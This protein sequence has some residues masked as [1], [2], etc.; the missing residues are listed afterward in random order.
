MFASKDVFDIQPDIITSAK[1]LSSGYVPLAATIFSD[2]IW[3][4]ISAPNPDHVFALG[5][6]YSGHPVACAAALKNIEIIEREKICE[7]VRETGPYLEEKL[8]TLRDL[9]IVGDVR[10]SR[11]MMGV[12]NVKNIETKE[13]F[14]KETNIASRIAKKC[15]ESGVIVRP[16]GNFIVISPPLILT[17]DQIDDLVE[18]LRKGIGATVDELRKEGVM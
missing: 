4:V 14:P 7:H 13:V 12:E 2:E 5:Y 1:G 6:T 10:G 3:D 8:N 17:R 9:P 11:F 15:Q 18:A 16:V